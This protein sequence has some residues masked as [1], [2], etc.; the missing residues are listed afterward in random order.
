MMHNLFSQEV[1]LDLVSCQIRDEHL[2]PQVHKIVPRTL[3]LFS[4]HAQ[5][6][7]LSIK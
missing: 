2:E 1:V 7:G 5:K 4:G 3:Q 6:P